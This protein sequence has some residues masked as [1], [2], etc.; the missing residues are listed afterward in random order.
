MSK[1]ITFYINNEL[2]TINLGEDKKGIFKDEL[3]KLIPTNRNI[4]TKELLAAFIQ[5]TYKIIQYEDELDII[6]ESLPD[7]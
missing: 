5:Q 2:Y 3:E 7:I 4:K 6:V 1:K